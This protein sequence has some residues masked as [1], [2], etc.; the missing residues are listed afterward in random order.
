MMSYRTTWELAGHPCPLN[1]DVIAFYIFF[2]VYTSANTRSPV[3]DPRWTSRG[4]RTDTTFRN[5]RVSWTVA[6]YHLYIE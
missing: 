2:L 3:L 5:R 6:L 1:V 4:R